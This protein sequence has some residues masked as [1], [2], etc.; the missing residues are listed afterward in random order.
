M[1]VT[2]TPNT[3]QRRVRRGNFLLERT[4][5]SAEKFMCHGLNGAA[6]E[7]ASQDESP[8]PTTGGS[9]ATMDGRN[10]TAGPPSSPPLPAASPTVGGAAAGSYEFDRAEEEAVEITLVACSGCSRNFSE[11]A[12]AKHVNVCKQ[13]FGTKRKVFSAAD[14]RA[15]SHLLASH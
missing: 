9:P 10:G 15:V 11:Q 5:S 3:E 1:A 13:V 2:S 14:Q 6:V 4:A 7:V 12:L 8:T